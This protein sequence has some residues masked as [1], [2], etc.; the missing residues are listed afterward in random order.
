M[1]GIV[2]G[3]LNDGTSGSLSFLDWSAY[4]TVYNWSGTTTSVPT[5][6]WG[7]FINITGEGYLV[8]ARSI[9]A[10]ST[11]AN[12][13][14]RVTVDGTAYT[15]T[16]VSSPIGEVYQ[17]NMIDHPI[18]YKTSLKVEVYNRRGG[19]TNIGLDYTYLQKNTTPGTG[20]TLLSGTRLMAY[21]TN[22]NSTVSNVAS[23]TGAGYILGINYEGF[24]NLTSQD[25][26]GSLTIDSTSIFSGRALINTGTVLKKSGVFQGPIRFTSNFT[27]GI[28]VASATNSTALAR[29]WYTL[30]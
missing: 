11:S 7:T 28:A 13:D 16:G 1:R 5:V 17:G 27:V 25:V 18:Y 8:F 3:G 20:Q 6:S 23:I 29:V 24:M 15:F 21:G 12:A 22:T 14:I 26:L 4:T 9:E 2:R 30:D 10:I 19:A